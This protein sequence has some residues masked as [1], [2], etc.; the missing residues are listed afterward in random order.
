MRVVRGYWDC[1]VIS[2]VYFLVYY[3]FIS[4][5]LFMLVV[6]SMPECLFQRSKSLY[7]HEKLYRNIQGNFVYYSLALGTTRTS[8]KFKRLN[9]MWYN[10]I[11]VYYLR[12]I[13]NQ[14][15]CFKL[16]YIYVF[17]KLGNIK[18]VI[19]HIFHELFVSL[20]CLVL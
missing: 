17:E 13:R 19:V 20:V 16:K 12:I 1:G 9:N 10:H 5:D 7:L 8:F 4:D 2:T 11:L 14:L 15:F 6:F 18:F 3:H